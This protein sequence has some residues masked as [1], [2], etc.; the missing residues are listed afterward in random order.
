[1]VICVGS[2]GSGKSTFVKQ[3]LS[4]YVRINNDFLKNKENCMKA[5]RTN[6]MEGK[7]VVVDN[8]NPTKEVRAGYLKIAKDLKVKARCLFFDTSKEV[9][10]HNNKQREIN[11]HRDHLS[12]KVP[13]IAL[14]IFFK[15]LAHPSLNEGFENIIT[16]NFIPVFQNKDDEEFYNA[17]QE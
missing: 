3:Y 17:T 10:K 6:L 5:C 13:I 11:L 15:N 2:P 16:V 14:H 8:T 1:M 9:C 12:K 4:D 7:S